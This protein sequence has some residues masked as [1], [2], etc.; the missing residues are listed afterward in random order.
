MPST[1]PTS[2]AAAT[3]THTTRL[4]LLSGFRLLSLTAGTLPGTAGQPVTCPGERHGRAS[5]P[6]GLSAG[7]A[8]PHARDP[9]QW[10]ER[11]ACCAASRRVIVDLASPERVASRRADRAA[12]RRSDRA[13]AAT[14]ATPGSWSPIAPTRAHWVLPVEPG[15]LAHRGQPRRVR[16]AVAHGMRASRYVERS[17]TLSR[18]SRIVHARAGVR[19]FAT[20]APGRSR[21][22]RARVREAT[23][24]AP[25]AAS[26]SAWR[27]HDG[28]AVSRQR[29]ESGWLLRQSAPASTAW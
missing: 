26:G 2:A 4:A 18:W 27:A 19:T 6:P 20:R 8:W 10:R 11:R 15:P 21:I 9:G 28:P 22:G 1:K 29:P 24:P 16:L 17:A 23:L 3:R 7:Q 25:D 14:A 13:S 12:S 5:A